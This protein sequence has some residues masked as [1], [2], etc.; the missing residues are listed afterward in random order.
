MP[1]KYNLLKD[2]L[3]DQRGGGE[4]ELIKILLRRENSTYTPNSQP[5]IST[6][7]C[8]GHVVT[9]DL[10]TL[11]TNPKRSRSGSTYQE[12][13]DLAILRSA[14]RTVREPGA[15]GPL[16]TGGRSAN[17]NRMTKRALQH[18]DG[19]CL[20]HGQSAS[21]W[22]CADGPRR[23]GRRSAKLQPAKN[24]W[25]NGSKRRRSRTHDEHEEP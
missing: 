12:A 19:P 23:P 7:V 2:R 24:S 9:T 8:Q 25:P 17:R 16:P 11:G 18:A 4:W 20:V 1:L 5:R 13:K 22:C 15:D 21:N 6:R 10:P 14:G 3:G